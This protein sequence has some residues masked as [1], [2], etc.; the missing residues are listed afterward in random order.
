MCL[1]FNSYVEQ[2]M[3]DK[4]LAFLWNPNQQFLLIEQNTKYIYIMILVNQTDYINAIH[5]YY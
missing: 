5:M 2:E 4:L 1:S 3:G